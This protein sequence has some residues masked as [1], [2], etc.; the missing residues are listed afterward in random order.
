MRQL[1]SLIIRDGDIPAL[2][3]LRAYPS[4]VI[5][6]VASIATT[7]RRDFVPMLGLV[8]SASVRD[9]FESP[10][11]TGLAR[12]TNVRAVVEGAEPLASALALSDNGTDVTLEIINGLGE[13][14]IG[15]RHTPMSD[16]LH[17]LLRELFRDE[18]ADDAEYATAFDRAEVML[19]ALAADTSAQR[20]WAGGFGRYTWRNKHSSTPVELQM[21]DELTQQCE[22]CG[23]ILDGLFGRSVDRAISAFE[24]VKVHAEM[25]RRQQW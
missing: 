15:G 10:E 8:A 24:S 9:R 14:K 21:L 4:L 25:V 12:F 17:S 13:K 1:T 19:D 7:S 23:P 3:H 22:A 16:H 6:Y 20:G 18:L 5:M 11:S 2:L